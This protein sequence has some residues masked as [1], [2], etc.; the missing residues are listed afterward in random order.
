MIEATSSSQHRRHGMRLLAGAALLLCVLCAACTSP[1]LRKTS[2]HRTSDVASSTQTATASAIT[3]PPHPASCLG[4]QLTASLGEHGPA[5]G[6]EGVVILLHNGSSTACRLSGVPTLQGVD[7]YGHAT[8]L[9][10][11]A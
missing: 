2:A 3:A 4:S 9:A 1:T 10:F 7:R 5:S 11:R 8:R 6:T